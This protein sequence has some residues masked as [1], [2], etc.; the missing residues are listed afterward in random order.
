MS[1]GSV[2]RRG[3]AKFE[4]FLPFL[5]LEGILGI[6]NNKK[7]T[8]TGNVMKRLL[9]GRVHVG[10]HVFF[11]NQDISPMPRFVHMVILLIVHISFIS[12][13]LYYI[14]LIEN[15]L[16]GPIFPNKVEIFQLFTL[17]LV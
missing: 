15:L 8:W 13:K 3:G 6:G 11:Y 4:I 1:G 17:T 14:L 7:Y 2:C 10:F 9:L 12:C 5:F 16:L